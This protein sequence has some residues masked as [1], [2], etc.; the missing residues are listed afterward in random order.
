MVG[1]LL[2][3]LAPDTMGERSHELVQERTT[4]AGLGWFLGS[5]ADFEANFLALHP[6][7]FFG[8][9]NRAP[10]RGEFTTGRVGGTPTKCFD[11]VNPE[12]ELFGPAEKN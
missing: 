4:V 11:F 5:R 3:P 2:T 12:T 7:H 9:P 8:N 6:P 10:L 1:E